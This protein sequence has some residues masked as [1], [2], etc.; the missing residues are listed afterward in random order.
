MEFESSSKIKIASALCVHF[1]L[2][3]FS[4]AIPFHFV[5][6]CAAFIACVREKKLYTYLRALKAAKDS[7]IVA[8]RKN[9]F[10]NL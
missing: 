2:S 4:R 7:Q 8:W 6:Q 10:D 3:L 1:M 9:L 5:K